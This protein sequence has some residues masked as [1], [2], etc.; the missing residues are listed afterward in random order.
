MFSKRELMDAIAECEENPT[1]Y[2]DCMKL[3]TFYTLYDHL[4][5]PATSSEQVEETTIGNYGDTEFLKE[6]SG[7]DAGKVWAVMDELM[8][9]IK[10]MQPRLYEGI[11]RKVESQR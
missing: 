5:P 2:P 9:T 6:I 7:L 3:A 4:Y 11:L 1:T 8:T 10:A